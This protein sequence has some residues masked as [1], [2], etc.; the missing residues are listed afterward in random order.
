MYQFEAK[1]VQCAGYR[2]YGSGVCKI[3]SAPTHI[4]NVVD[5]LGTRS[6][7]VQNFHV[8]LE[9]AIRHRAFVTA[10]VNP[11]VS[12]PERAVHQSR[13]RHRLIARALEIYLEP[14]WRVCTLELCAYAARNSQVAFIAARHALTSAKRVTGTTLAA[15]AWLAQAQHTEKVRE[16]LTC[17]EACY[18]NESQAKGLE[19]QFFWCS[20]C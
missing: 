8:V 9:R 14:S 13:W 3:G 20:F 12:C 19:P 6:K 11:R 17:L 1:R 5:Q 10:P 15:F 16:W 18:K 2:H 4:I 7:I